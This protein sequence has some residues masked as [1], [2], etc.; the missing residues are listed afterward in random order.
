GSALSA[1][2][3]EWIG[4]SSRPASMTNTSLRLDHS[5]TP[6][7]SLFARFGR[8]PSR[9]EFGTSQV[10]SFSARFTSFT[11]GMN[12][13]VGSRM[14]N[15]LRGNYVY[16]SASSAWTQENAAGLPECY[17]A[18]VI[19]AL[20]RSPQDCNTF[21]RLSVGGLGQLASGREA[22]QRQRQWNVTDTAN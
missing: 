11:L 13:R 9:S 6:G 16:A 2:S 12:A 15:D 19:A 7:V 8:A 17:F 1:D 14:V 18:G 3:L 21:F 4:R 5:L 10:N 22:G 20:S